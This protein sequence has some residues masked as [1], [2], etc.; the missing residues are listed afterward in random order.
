MATLNLPRLKPEVWLAMA[1]AGVLAWAVAEIVRAGDKVTPESVGAKLVELLAKMGIGAA[2]KTASVT[3]E[4]VDEAGNAVLDEILP[5]SACLASMRAGDSA[6]VLWNCS[7][8]DAIAWFNAGKP[9]FCNA[10]GDGRQIYC[11]Q[12]PSAP[13]KK[14]PGK[15]GGA[16][17]SWFGEVVEVQD[18]TTFEQAAA[19]AT[20][21][22][23]VYTPSVDESRKVITPVAGL[24][25]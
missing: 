19:W 11:G 21:A 3:W 25:G 12:Q 7:P 16:T 14:T 24:R 6:G 5:Q 20:D 23:L 22:G 2:K 18:M 4:M 8:G 1:G 17:G 10:S 9:T 15:T 13:A